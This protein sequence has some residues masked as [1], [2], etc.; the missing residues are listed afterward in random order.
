MPVYLLITTAGCFVPFRAT[1]CQVEFIEEVQI[2]QIQ[3]SDFGYPF[4]LSTVR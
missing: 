2:G 1:W 3:I 4:S